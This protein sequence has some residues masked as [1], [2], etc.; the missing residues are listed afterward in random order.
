MKRLIS[1]KNRRFYS[2]DSDYV[3]RS[4]RSHAARR[5]MTLASSDSAPSAAI[6]RILSQPTASVATVTVVIA[7]VSFRARR[8]H[9]SG[10][11]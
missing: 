7:L 3:I 11:R 1:L 2:R 6:Q 8:C 10:H 5:R 4:E 9:V